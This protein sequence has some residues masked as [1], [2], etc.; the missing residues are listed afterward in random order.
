MC[1]F[2]TPGAS[3]SDSLKS[4][5]RWTVAHYGPSFGSSCYYSSKCLSDPTMSEQWAGAGYAWVYQCA[6]EAGCWKELFLECGA[7]LECGA[8]LGVQHG[9]LGVRH[10]AWSVAAQLPRLRNGSLTVPPH[11]PPPHPHAGCSQMSWWQ[12]A[13]G[14]SSLRSSVLTSAY[15][16]SQC[17]A[18]FGSTVTPQQVDAFNAQYG[19][20]APNA[21]HVVAL[22]GSDDPWQGACVNATLSASYVEATA[23]CDG[24]GHCGDLSTPSGTA[25]PAIIAQQ[26]LVKAY[27]SAWVAEAQTS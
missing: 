22:N 23:T 9:F 15:W 5:A 2:F 16:T 14:P 20:A 7:M 11:P 6:C 10:G 1:S 25:P 13:N 19:G 24:C 3:P 8:V 26:A 27:L 21:T 4:L 17:E 18:A 12:A